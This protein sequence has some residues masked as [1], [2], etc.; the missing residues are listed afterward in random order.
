FVPVYNDFGEGVGAI[1]FNHDITSRKQAEVEIIKALEKEKELV[2]LRSRFITM[3]SHE[4]RTPLA[5]ILTS[6]ELLKSFGHQMND[7]KKIQN[8]KRIE[9]AVKKMTNLLE[10][11]LLIN[12]A[13]SE[14]IEFNTSILDLEA[15]CRE[16]IEE[17]K[18]SLSSKYNFKFSCQGECSQVEIDEKL[19]RQMLTNLV[20]NAAKYS[21]RGGTIYLDL[22]CEY[23]Q[24]TFKVRDEGIGIPEADKERIF[25][26]FHRATNVGSIS[27]TGL[28]LSIIK[29][30]VELHGGSIS[31]ESE[32]G[33]GTTFTVCIN[34][35]QPEDQLGRFCKMLYPDSPKQYK[36]LKSQ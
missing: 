31:L 28:G 19:L 9:A 1:A 22:I 14:C 4:F 23:G 15:I 34:T 3:A 26:R 10:D 20:S 11:I 30:A 2:D 33:V 13:E 18:F 32:V 12:R 5:T 25:E 36:V 6:S 29:Q 7:D 16:T 35:S 17:I 21:P 27:G 8:Y 24:A